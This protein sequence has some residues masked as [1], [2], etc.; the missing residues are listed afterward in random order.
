MSI[1]L[2]LFGEILHSFRGNKEYESIAQQL[3]AEYKFDNG[4][5]GLNHLIK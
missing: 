2:I 1:F 4:F 3:Y 5:H